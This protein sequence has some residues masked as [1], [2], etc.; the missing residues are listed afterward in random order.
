MVQCEPTKLFKVGRWVGRKHAQ[1]IAKFG[2]R[3]K[4]MLKKMKN[5]CMLLILCTMNEHN[6]S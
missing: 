2:H 4:A 3:F 5:L 1:K 6:I